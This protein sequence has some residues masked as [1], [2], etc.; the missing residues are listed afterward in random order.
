VNLFKTLIISSLIGLFFSCKDEPRV[1]SKQMILDET[2]SL[3]TYY[4]NEIDSLYQRSIYLAYTENDSFLP[5]I[6]YGSGASHL[7]L[8]Q[9]EL[10]KIFLPFLDD[11]NII[12]VEIWFYVSG[13][14]VLDLN[15]K[16]TS[17]RH[18]RWE[19]TEIK[20]TVNR[21]ET[22]VSYISSLLYDP[23]WQHTA[24]ADSIKQLIREKYKDIN[25]DKEEERINDI[26]L[27]VKN[28]KTDDYMIEINVYRKLQNALF[29][30]VKDEKIHFVE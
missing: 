18:W 20:D 11:E 1:I 28:W 24:D 2:D 30:R 12:E 23:Y 15:G 26:M 6:M 27:Y 4:L 25:I 16:S 13:G 19:L 14:F 10:E 9:E 5:Q 29:D 3:N 7:H 22:T 21:Q 17:L 8:E